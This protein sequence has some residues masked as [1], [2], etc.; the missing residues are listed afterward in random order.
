[1]ECR[2]QDILGDLSHFGDQ[3]THRE[4][5][6]PVGGPQARSAWTRGRGC[7][8]AVAGSDCS[9]TD[10]INSQVTPQGPW[11]SWLTCIERLHDRSKDAGAAVDC[12][13]S[14]IAGDITTR[15]DRSTGPIKSAS[16]PCAIALFTYHQMQFVLRERSSGA[17]TACSEWW[18]SVVG[19]P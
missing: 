6:T 2:G 1:M 19:R 12:S 17:M 16:E 18:Q 4:F 7:Q 5:P 3:R 9:V 11:A 13:A 14:A 8:G 15:R 10:Q